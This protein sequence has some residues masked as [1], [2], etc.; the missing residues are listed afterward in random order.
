MKP[1]PYQRQ[2]VKLIEYFNGRALLADEMGLGKTLQALKYHR[3]NHK[4]TVPAVVVCPATL[5]WNW[6]REALNAIGCRAEVLEGRQPR[7]SRLDVK[8]KL[9]VVN[10]DILPYW[11]DW[12]EELGPRAAF[13][14]ECQYIKNRSAQ[15]TKAVKHL[16]RMCDHVVMMSGTPLLN[17]PSELFPAL[18][19][20]LPDVFPSFL[21][22]A[23]D[24]CKPRRVHGR[25]DYGGAKNLDELHDLLDETCM[26][27]RLKKDVLHQLPDKVRDV[28]PIQLDRKDAKEYAF[29]EKNFIRWVATTKGK[30]K[31]NKARRAQAVVKVGYLKRLAAELKMKLI[32]Q[33]IDDFLADSDGKLVVFGVHHKVLQPLAERYKS[34]C[35]VVDGS[36]T[37]KKRQHAVDKFQSKASVRLF[38]GNLQAAGVGLTLTAASSVAFVELGWKPGEH[39]QGEDRIH[40]IGQT[41]AA[42]IYYLVARNTIEE[43]L[44][45]IIQ[46]KQRVIEQTL[47][48]IGQ[49]DD[50]DIF[51]LLIKKI[52]QREARVA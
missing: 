4:E 42:M 36:V 33:W 10:Y 35:V 41:N 22:F 18:N 51:D 1:Y 47:D 14:D 17:S 7:W 45:E 23:M 48:G 20:L 44:C 34:K 6:E 46:R 24:F 39:T 30:G 16:C 28:I 38:I 43:D 2:G 3:R 19:I 15:R 25:W 13:I 12:F 5:K 49:G 32:I 31:A 27:R 40:R 11:L 29:A 37:G 8:H 26:I 9:I 21:P 52:E 50:L